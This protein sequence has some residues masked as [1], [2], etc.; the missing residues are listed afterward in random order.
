MH[1]KSTCT[2]EKSVQSRVTLGRVPVDNSSTPLQVPDKKNKQT[3]PTPVQS[4]CDLSAPVSSSEPQTASTTR[5]DSGSERQL[6]NSSKTSLTSEPSGDLEL[7]QSKTSPTHSK[8]SSSAGKRVLSGD[9][10]RQK[11]SLRISSAGEIRV[12]LSHSSPDIQTASSG[13]KKRSQTKT[14]SQLSTT[15]VTTGDSKHNLTTESTQHH[16]DGRK[17]R[18]SS[19]VD[20]PFWDSEIVPLLTALESTPY[21]ETVRLCE[22]CD[23]LWSR[24]EQHDL[25]GRTGGVGGTKRRAAVLRTV[26]KLLDHRDPTLLLKVAKII[27][28]VSVLNVVVTCT[29]FILSCPGHATIS[30]LPT[31]GVYSCCS[32]ISQTCF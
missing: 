4:L 25:L 19:T 1:V 20:L 23:S 24:L 22:V 30:C 27:T 12:N 28:A 31:L 14:T 11:E 16:S 26:F 5:N 17:S 9:L 15:S 2:P 32:L 6:N 8:R 18:K 10:T 13:K 21:S 29:W 7:K 3:P